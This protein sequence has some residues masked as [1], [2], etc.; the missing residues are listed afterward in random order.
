M[1]LTYYEYINEGKGISN[2]IKTLSTQIT[3]HIAKSIKDEIFNFN[4]N[5][6]I[7]EISQINNIQIILK[8]IEQ[9]YNS[10]FYSNSSKLDLTLEFDLPDNI[11]Y[12][13][14]HEIVVHE[15]T[16]LWEYYNIVING[17]RFP[18]YDNIKKALIGTVHQDTFDIFS[19]FRNLVYLTLDNELNARVSQTYQSLIVYNIK[20]K[21]ILWNILKTKKIW[22]KYLEIQNF[23]PITFSNDLINLIGFDLTIILISDFNS[24]LTKN[25]V[26]YKFY[27][28]NLINENDVIS[29]FN[30]WSDIFKKKLK[31]HYKKLDKIIDEVIIKF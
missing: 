9:N 25:S 16:H 6:N 10:K 3:G 1:I 29:Y 27:K 30:E 22:K 31:K 2:F 17:K 26:D 12:Y 15:L 11:N 28:K 21:N 4:L 5:L 23:E 8:S 19:Y 18:L 20:D 14:L 13:Y 7:P 24:H